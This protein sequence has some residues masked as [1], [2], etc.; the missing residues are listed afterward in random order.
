MIRVG[1]LTAYLFGNRIGAHRVRVSSGVD[2]MFVVRRH[3]L[4]RHY[5]KRL[6][7]V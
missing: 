7:P 2:A 1:A 5:P 3:Y 4:S 6:R